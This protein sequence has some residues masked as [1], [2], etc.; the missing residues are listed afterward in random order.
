LVGTERGRHRLPPHVLILALFASMV[1]HGFFRAAL[2]QS[3]EPL[4]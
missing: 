4:G 3:T 2:M 1:L